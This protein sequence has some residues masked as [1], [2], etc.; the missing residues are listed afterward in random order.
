VGPDGEDG[1]VI[2]PTLAP[3]PVPSTVVSDMIGANAFLY[4]GADAVQTGVADGTIDAQRVV[5]VTWPRDRP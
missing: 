4:T 3:P 2:V 5:V 1:E